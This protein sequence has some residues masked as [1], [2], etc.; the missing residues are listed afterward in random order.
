MATY[1]QIGNAWLTCGTP[2]RDQ[3]L[4]GCLKASYDVTNEDPGTANHA[5]RLAWANVILTGTDAAVLAKVN[6]MI[7]Y[8]LASNATF[9]ADPAAATDND[10][11]F[12]VASQLNALN[13]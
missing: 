9:Q 1:A 10:V 2:M 8:A 12:I 4:G 7:R 5:N 6:E 11:A 13:P 3:W